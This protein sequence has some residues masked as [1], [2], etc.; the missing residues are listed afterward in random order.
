[1]VWGHRVWIYREIDI[2]ATGN[3]L[4]V[5]YDACNKNG[6]S[7]AH[8]DINN[9]AINTPLTFK[10][11]PWDDV[12]GSDKIMVERWTYCFSFALKIKNCF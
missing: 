12:Q 4:C 5:S 10:N 9:T 2:S 7:D 1:M 8:L 11:T 3:Y 6:K